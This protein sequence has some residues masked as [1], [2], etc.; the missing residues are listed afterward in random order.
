M[1]YFILWLIL[2]IWQSIFCQLE[3]SPRFGAQVEFI[4][5]KNFSGCKVIRVAGGTSAE[6]Q[7]QAEDII[8]KL[9]GKT[10]LSKEFFL[11]E[12]M[13]HK[14]DSQI[15]LTVLRDK[16]EL[17]LKGKV[18]GRPYETDDNAKV[19][20]DQASFKGGELRVIINK[21]Y[22]EEKMPAML[23]IPGYTCSSID[24]LPYYHP[25]KRIID[26]YV[27]AGYVTLRIEKSGLGDSKNTPPCESCDL[28]DEI[29]NFEVGLKKIEVIA[30]C[31]Y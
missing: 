22:K 12:F 7:L 18:I 6:L 11:D 15:E 29:E 23:F 16:K 31:R 1:K 3:R 28:L 17:V 4:K 24:D 26:A 9:D 8:L 19:I 20:Y 5:D 2:T 13:K 30:L 25:Y 10:I 14:I 27:D 21:P